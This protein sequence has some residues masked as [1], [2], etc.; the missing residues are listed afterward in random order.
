MRISVCNVGGMG[1]V[2]ERHGSRTHDDGLY[3]NIDKSD[4]D[5]C[6]L[7]E[8]KLFSR[9]RRPEEYRWLRHWWGQH[10]DTENIFLSC[11]QRQHKGSG[12][13]ILIKPGTV[14]KLRDKRESPLGR[15]MIIVV[16]MRA[17]TYTLACFYGHDGPS[18]AISHQALENMYLDLQE[19][20][21]E[22][23]GEVI[24]A[25]DFNFVLHP[26]DAHTQV[27]HKP[28][29]SALM[30]Q[31]I[32]Q[33][34]LE[35]AWLYLNDEDEGHTFTSKVTGK[36][37]RLD[38]I[39]IAEESM[40]LPTIE[41]GPV[42]KTADHKMLQLDIR[43][44]KTSKPL[45]KHPDY[46]LMSSHYR[47]QL[48][49][50]VRRFLVTQSHRAGTYQ[51]A[52]LDDHHQRLI[53]QLQNHPEFTFQ[54]VPINGTSGLKACFFDT[55]TEIID[56]KIKNMYQQIR[57][58]DVSPA[59]SQI[60]ELMDEIVDSFDNPETQG[61]SR[62][63]P[64]AILETL[65]AEILQFSFRYRKLHKASNPIAIIR[66]Q[67]AHIAKMKAEGL[68]TDNSPKL[69]EAEEIVRQQ[70]R[71][72]QTAQTSRTTVRNNLN[73]DKSTKQFLGRGKSHRAK[74][75]I[76]KIKKGDD[77][78]LG[79]DAED[80][81][82]Q[83]FTNLLGTS[84][85]IDPESNVENILGTALPNVPR[86][87]PDQAIKLDREI[88]IDELDDVVR[89]SHSGSSPG[90]NGITYQLIKEIWPLIRRLFFKAT[91]EI[92]GNNDE[93]P[94]SHLP[95]DW[96]NRRIILIP[97]PGKPED[98]DG[99]Y[100]P[101]SLLQIPYKIV[102]AVIAAR[103]KEATQELIGVSQKGYMPGRC[104]MD[105]SRAVIDIRNFA[106]GTATPLAILGVDFSK[107]FDTVSHEGL[108]KI[109]RFY[110]MPERFIQR[111]RL[112]LS[113]AKI[114]L[115]INGRR[116]PSFDLRDGTGQGDPI[117]SYLFN[118]VV[119][120]FLNAIIHSQDTELFMI[121]SHTCL[122]EAYADDVHIF[123]KGDSPKTVQEIIRI[124]EDF[125]KLTGLALSKPKTEYLSVG[126]SLSTSLMAIRLG[127]KMVSEIKFVGI[128]TS[129]NPSAEEDSRNF[130]NAFDKIGRVERSWG[131]RRPSPLGAV[132][133][134]RSL[135]ASTA[136]HILTNIS[137]NKDERT[138]FEKMTRKFI[139]ASSRPQVRMGVMSQPIYRGGINHIDI[140]FFTTALRTRWFR[141][142]TRKR[143]GQPVTESWIHAL[144]YWLAQYHL[145][146]SDI[147]ALGHKDIAKLG[148]RLR[149]NECHFWGENLISFARVVKIFE[150][151]T[152][153]P[154]ALP[155]FGGI[156][157]QIATRSGSSEVLTAL[158]KNPVYTFIFHQFKTVG[159][160]FQKVN[161]DRVDLGQPLH[162]HIAFEGTDLGDQQTRRK[163]YGGFKKV[164][165]LICK[166]IGDLPIYDHSCI[167]VVCQSPF[168][169]DHYALQYRCLKQMK[170]SSFVYRALIDD[171]ATRLSL[172]TPK[173]YITSRKDQLHDISE[174]EWKLS[175]KR[176]SKIHCSPRARWQNI[177][178]FLRTVWTPLKKFNDT[179][180][181][182]DACCPGCP[183][184]WPANTAHLL[185][186]CSGLA[187][188]VW[189]FVSDLLE[190]VSGKPFNISKFK[191]LYFH[192][193]T[194]L[195]EFAVMASAKRAIIRVINAVRFPIHPRVSMRFLVTEITGTA[196]TN[197]HALRD[198]PIWLQIKEVVWHK[199]Q[200]M[201]TSKNYIAP[202]R[203]PS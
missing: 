88:T 166:A 182:D 73:E 165:S 151:K 54:E 33:L 185:Y 141:I 97:K 42:H 12:T 3:E 98:D 181:L 15:H 86:L 193:V 27:A 167:Q 45:P 116:H 43:P 101:I 2:T 81:M 107:A 66:L 77:I 142:L 159:D 130:K 115:D 169:E 132:I 8:T 199:W 190:H 189:N 118:L 58:E 194:N 74:T 158:S 111:I 183:D 11:T 140:N 14:F 156:L 29:T 120:I 44:V 100:R 64:L 24:I 34:Q 47:E 59:P 37:S 13:A 65:M 202:P 72:I 22:Y 87:T 191:A 49:N 147:P 114:T 155:I 63:S 173:S 121:E 112:L 39:Y 5:I 110:N 40:H 68:T 85:K 198:T 108:V 163:V 113:G 67:E 160:L 139:W 92:M 105:V 102:A 157:Q 127:L 109:L 179:G 172:H 148:R 90:M 28:R 131:W 83:L 94:A 80:H 103:L 16:E 36:T 17:R 161:N 26:S 52:P 1:R 196:N 154:T 175:L 137:L 178:V 93:P 176:L 20:Q 84:S 10:M 162:P 188:N 195:V 96:C 18:D 4:A 168:K 187:T 57:G 197:I 23:Q 21:A 75:R 119:E 146:A 6:F 70:V 144:N 62:T 82:V 186:E 25:G 135:M 61:A 171:K 95:H 19:L 153:N 99:S 136:T 48:C 152:D 200:E 129:A 69:A 203:P 41:I 79:N 138:R 124:A 32:N 89:K 184:H 143:N 7:T 53:N 125:Q 31:I 71:T 145:Q 149:S 38:R 91:L 46:L 123:A 170:G 56:S 150:E 9:E 192:H 106:A 133:I 177:Q 51:E 174:V 76:S 60:Q 104:A 164:T 35:D 78:L 180:I 126:A 117:S 30:E 50:V 134:V 128:Y 55:S 201:K 122:P